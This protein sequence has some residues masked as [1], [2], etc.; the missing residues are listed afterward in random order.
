[1][2]I[3][4]QPVR[5]CIEFMPTAA[6]EKQLAINIILATYKQNGFL[7][8]IT[9][10]L[11]S[12]EWLAKGDEGENSTQNMFKT[13]KRGEKLDLTKPNLTVNDLVAEGLRYDLTVPLARFYANNKDNLP[14]PFK[15]I[16]VGESFRCE[17]PQQGRYRQFTQCDLD[18]FGDASIIGEIEIITTALEAYA[19]LGLKNVVVKINNR[20]LLQ[21]AAESYGFKPQQFKQLFITLDKYDKIGTE[22][23][24]K[25]LVA[26]GFK[27]ETLY[28][29]FGLIESVKESGL[30]F[31]KQ[32]NVV[33]KEVD[34]MD[35]IIKTVNAFAGVFGFSA[36]FDIGIIRGQDYYTSYVFE[37]FATGVGYKRA[38]GGGGRYDN[39][40]NKMI[41]ENI[42]AVGFGLGLDSTIVAINEQATQDL[43]NYKKRIA[44]FYESTDSTLELYNYK[45]NLMNKENDYQVSIMPTPKNYNECVRRLKLNGFDGTVKLSQKEIKFF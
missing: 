12:L 33:P 11:E 31:L 29:F 17:R 27:A 23:C 18:I 14:V 16:Q 20:R 35:K 30:D 6:E 19:N 32:N 34:E 5:G 15:A 22:E 4:T 21:A 37:F 43:K 26:N 24:I 36:V 2:K 44:L 38:I 7:Q 45:F 39:M 28:S 9:P 1:M 8:I 40:L 25:E 13:L 3:S 10:M 42:P 41:G